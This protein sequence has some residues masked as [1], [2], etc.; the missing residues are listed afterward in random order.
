M[1]A[2]LIS[3]A[4]A[5]HV[6]ILSILSKSPHEVG[7]QHGDPTVAPDFRGLPLRPASIHLVLLDRRRA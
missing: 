2:T 5:P 3:I 7:R 6:A 1:G 4:P